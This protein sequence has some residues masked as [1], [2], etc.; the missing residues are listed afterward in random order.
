LEEV[1]IEHDQCEK[2]LMPR[3][4]VEEPANLGIEEAAV[5]D[6]CQAVD[7][8]ELFELRE[9][10]EELLLRRGG[11]ANRAEA[12]CELRGID[13]LSEVFIRAGFEAAHDLFVILHA[14]EDHDV[15]MRI[16]NAARRN[17]AEVD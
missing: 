4:Q 5:V 14:A 8:R 10:E 2:S 11:T 3:G 1:E 9:T 13:R 12:S 6:L 17:A 7:R 15:A 16:G